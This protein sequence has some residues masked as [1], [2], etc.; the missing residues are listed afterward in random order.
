MAGTWKQQVAGMRELGSTTT[1]RR[2]WMLLVVL[3]GLL[4]FTAVAL[5]KHAGEFDRSFNHGGVATSRPAGHRGV[6]WAVALGKKD[7]PVVAGSSGAASAG[8]GVVRYTRKG[9]VD[10]SFGSNGVQTIFNQT[11]KATA[12]AVDVAKGGAVVAAGQSCQGTVCHMAI[13]K[14]DSSG[15]LDQGFGNDGR[16]ELSFG[17]DY[18]LATGV[19]FRPDGKIL[20]VGSTCVATKDCDFALVQLLPTGDPDP[21]FGAGDGKVVT[22]FQDKAGDPINARA[23]ALA[24]DPRGRIA[25]SGASSFRRGVLALY[26][27][28]GHF[29]DSFGHDGK[30][31]PNLPHLGGIEG[32]AVDAKH[33]I[34]VVGEDKKKPGA[35]WTVARFG[36]HGDLDSSF[37][38]DG[39][40]TTGFSQDGQVSASGVAIDSKNRI[41]VAG[42]PWL[43]LARYQPNGHLN[44]SFGDH[45]R[46]TQKHIGAGFGGVTIDSHDRP[47]VPGAFDRGRFAVSR[48][49]G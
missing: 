49:L 17:T 7:K 22:S 1:A 44:K 40:V 35:R 32:L 9:K 34:V 25:V 8:F 36:K 4:A 42:I 13:A 14:Y 41:V 26:K 21:Q 31:V 19:K 47:V 18:S 43:S 29:V 30:L 28:H 38:N 46:F 10:S 2:G 6:A 33:K 12:C 45:G 15:Q 24:I 23:T 27:P 16:V 5:A 20:A 48:F 39:E 3:A 11:G 37:G